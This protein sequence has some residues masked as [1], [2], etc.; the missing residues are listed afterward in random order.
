MRTEYTIGKEEEDKR[1]G[2]ETARKMR[3]RY[4]RGK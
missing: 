1:N 2:K 3:A 4:L